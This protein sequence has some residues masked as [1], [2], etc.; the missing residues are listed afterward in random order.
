MPGRETHPRAAMYSCAYHLL[1]KVPQTCIVKPAAL[2]GDRSQGYGR[3]AQRL[4]RAWFTSG[5]AWGVGGAKTQ[6]KEGRQMGESWV[7]T[8]PE[9]R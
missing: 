8:A 5:T 4:E 1:H 9:G 3:D 7:L 2:D 6:G